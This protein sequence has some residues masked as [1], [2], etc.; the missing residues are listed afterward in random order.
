[1]GMFTRAFGRTTR[2]MGMGGTCTRMGLL[3]RGTGKRTSSTARVRRPGQ[4]VLVTREIT[5]KAKRTEW[6]DFNGQT[7]ALM[8]VSFKTTTSM[9][10]EYTYGQTTGGTRVNGKT[11]KC[12]ERVRSPGLTAE[13]TKGTTTT[14]RS[15]AR[16]YS[17]GPTVE[18]TMENGS[19]VNSM[20]RGYTP[21]AS[22]RSGRGSGRR[23]R[24]LDGSLT[25]NDF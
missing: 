20:G 9:V 15:K 18:N 17:H 7:G 6:A 24:G 8:R 4:T 2:L 14:T 19:T 10:E 1:M 22:K 11:T 13:S 3:T 25:M 5:L 16:G 23:E 12:T 21:L